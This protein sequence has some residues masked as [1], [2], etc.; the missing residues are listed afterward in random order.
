M[1]ASLAPPYPLAVARSAIKTFAHTHNAWPTVNQS[2]VTSA[3]MIGPFVLE[4]RIDD[5]EAHRQI[6][7]AMC[8]NRSVP[9]TIMGKFPAPP[10]RPDAE[11]PA[12]AITERI[13]PSQ[14]KQT[15]SVLARRAVIARSSERRSISIPVD[16][17]A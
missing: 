12:H 15:P 16:A 5:A 1:I 14:M 6:P 7:G 11:S 17:V 9:S 13:A 2:A 10:A 4:S 8:S 3:K